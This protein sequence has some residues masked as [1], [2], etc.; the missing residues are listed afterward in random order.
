MAAYDTIYSPVDRLV[1][2]DDPP[3]EDFPHTFIQ[4]VYTWLQTTRRELLITWAQAHFSASA[5]I[6][7]SEV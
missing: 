4:S 1:A 7:S 5:G 2:F 6:V 3:L